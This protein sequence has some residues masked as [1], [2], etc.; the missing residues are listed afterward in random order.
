M[1]W[2][3]RIVRLA[4]VRRAR[5]PK[6]RHARSTPPTA[7]ATTGPP[8][9][10]LTSVDAAEP[11][12]NYEPTQTWHAHSTAVRRRNPACANCGSRSGQTLVGTSRLPAAA[13]HQASQRGEGAALC[14]RVV[15]ASPLLAVQ[16]TH[17]PLTVPPPLPAAALRRRGSS[18]WAAP[19]LA[20]SVV[21]GSAGDQAAQPASHQGL[22]EDARGKA[23]KR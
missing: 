10:A 9:R 14:D 1:Q 19:A 16:L 22:H 21:C 12:C 23:F 5:D 20:C 6:R 15:P 4:A 7:S 13:R 17:A 18:A 3:G 11:S 8:S 2:R